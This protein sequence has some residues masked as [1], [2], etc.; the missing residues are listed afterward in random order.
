M[1]PPTPAVTEGIARRPMFLRRPAGRR[2]LRGW[3]I[4]TQRSTD[5]VAPVVAVATYRTTRLDDPIGQ[6]VPGDVGQGEDAD[7]LHEERVRRSV[8][9]GAMLGAQLGEQALGE[10]FKV[11]DQPPHVLEGTLGASAHRLVNV[12]ALAEGQEPLV[13]SL[14]ATHVFREL[15]FERLQL[16]MDRE[17][18]L[19]QVPAGLGTLDRGA[20]ILGRFG[21]SAVVPFPVEQQDRAREGAWTTAARLGVVKGADAENER[22]YRRDPVALAQLAHG[23]VDGIQRRRLRRRQR[24]GWMRGE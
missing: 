3:L 17:G 19:R 11:S 5:A 22:G 24:L 18:E 4:A 6:L 14:P 20:S 12:S 10:G 1:R 7:E 13:Q 8:A 21:A 23:K 16:A 2:G 15:R 9:D